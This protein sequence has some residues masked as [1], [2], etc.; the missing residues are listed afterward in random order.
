MTSTLKR[1]S[2]LA[3][4]T[5]NVGDKITPMDVD[6]TTTLIVAGA[7]ASRDYMPVHHI[8]TGVGFAA[9]EPNKQ[10]A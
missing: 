10:Q 3:W 4:D 1:T 7:I 2:T 6:V 5:I 9:W 8:I